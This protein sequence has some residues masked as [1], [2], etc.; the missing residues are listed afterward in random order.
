M[1][2]KIEE[3]INQF[4]ISNNFKSIYNEISLQFELGYFLK[5]KLKNYKVEFERNINNF[6]SNK[7]TF[8]NT[9]FTKHEIDIVIYDEVKN[10]SYAIELKY[11][12]K[13]A[14]GKRMDSFLKDIDFIEELKFN[15]DFKGG[16]V[17]TFID[18]TE[19][20][21]YKGNYQSDSNNAIFRS[22]G[23]ILYKNHYSVH[24]VDYKNNLKYFLLKI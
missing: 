7:E 8:D 10:E 18:A 3:L 5:E 6:C 1:I 14:Y 22:A 17:L 15:L 21:F 16:F 9:K 19:Y 4:L 20:G 12:R 2:S 11:P 24:W 23:E 13:K